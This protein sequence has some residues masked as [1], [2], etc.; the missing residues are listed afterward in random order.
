MFWQGISCALSSGQRI[1]SSR[2]PQTLAPCPQPWHIVRTEAITRIVETTP[3]LLSVRWRLPFCAM[4]PG[5]RGR[6]SAETPPEDFA[7]PNKKESSSQRS[8]TL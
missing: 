3:H 5:Q 2:A 7:G 1:V 4:A 6:E 8:E